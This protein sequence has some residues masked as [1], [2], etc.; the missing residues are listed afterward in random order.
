MLNVA[1]WLQQ[2]I[3]GCDWMSCTIDPVILIPENHTIRMVR[4]NILCGNY[5]QPTIIIYSIYIFS[6]K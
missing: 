4:E 2:L 5:Q 6:T 3:Y 1:K